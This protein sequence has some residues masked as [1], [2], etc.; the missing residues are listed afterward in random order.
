MSPPITQ[1]GVISDISILTFQTEIGIDRENQS[2]YPPEM[3]LVL[4]AANMAQTNRDEGGLFSQPSGRLRLGC[5]QAG[6]STAHP[7]CFVATTPRGS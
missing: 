4:I 3:P 7:P 5:G 2:I 1:W 6:H